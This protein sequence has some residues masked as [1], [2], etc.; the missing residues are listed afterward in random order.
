MELKGKSSRIQSSLGSKLVESNDSVISTLLI[1]RVKDINYQENYVIFVPITTNSTSRP[2]TRGTNQALLPSEFAGRNGFGRSY[3]V[4]NP[5]HVGDIVLIGLLESDAAKPIVISRYPDTKIASELTD[6]ASE[7]YE[8]ADFSNYATANKR[9]IVYPDQGYNIHDGRGN[10]TLKFSGNTFM[11]VRPDVPA[12]SHATDDGDTPINAQNIPGNSDS[13]GQSRNAI[14]QN[15]PEVIYGHRGNIN[16]DGTKDNHAY[17]VYIGQDGDY[18]VSMMQDDQDWRTY[19]EET[20]DGQIR[21][22]RQEDSKIFGTGSKSSEFLIDNNGYVTIRSQSTGLVLK[23]DGIYNL[24]GTKFTVDTDLSG[25]WDAI[26]KT[27]NGVKENKAQITVNANEI[28]TKVSTDELPTAIN[29]QLKPYDDSL[30]SLQDSYTDVKKT[31]DNMASDGIISGADKKATRT[32]WLQIQTEYPATVAQAEANGVDHSSLDTSYNTLSAYLEPILNAGGDTTVDPTE[33]DRNFSN[34]YNASFNVNTAIVAALRKLAQD[35]YDKAVQAGEDVGNALTQVSQATSED[36]LTGADKATLGHVWTQI[37]NQ[38][39]NDVSS[40]DAVKVDHNALDGAYNDLN[41][42]IQT[43]KIFADNSTI[44]IDGETLADKIKAYFK[45]EAVV[46]KQVADKNIQTLAEYGQDIDHQAT[47]IK[48]TSTKIALSAENIQKHSDSLSVMQGQLNVMA[49]QISGGVS[50]TDVTGIVNDSLSGT[51]LGQ[52]NQ[53]VLKTATKGQYM[54]GNNG[55]SSASTNGIISDYVAVTAGTA[56]SAKVY[57][58]TG[59]IKLSVMWYDSNKSFISGTE[60][61]GTGDVTNNGTAPTNASYAKVSTD[62]Y[63]F[64]TLFIAGNAPSAWAPSYVDAKGNVD[65]ANQLLKS[66]T[67]EQANISA[68]INANGNKKK[69]NV[70]NIDSMFANGNLV[71]TDIGALNGILTDISSDHSSDNSL[72]TQY[73]VDIAALNNYYGQLKDDING[74]LGQAEGSNVDIDSYRAKLTAYYTSRDT[75]LQAVKGKID[76]Q[77]SSAKQAL[78]NASNTANEVITNKY[79]NFA[80]TV[81]GISTKVGEVTTTANNASAAASTAQSSAN[82]AQSSANAAKDSAAS[83]ASAA[84]T[85]QVTANAAQ[86]SATNAASAASAAASAASATQKSL[87]TLTDDGNIS[88]IEKQTLAKEYATIKSNKAIDLAQATKYSVDA[89][90]YTNAEQAVET[91]VIPILNDMTT[92]TAVDRDKYKSTFSTYYNERTNLLNA[93]ADVAKNAA[94][95]AASAA[96]VA[97]GTAN[98]AAS[99]ASAAQSDLNNFKTTTTQKFSE[100]D[101]TA[102]G[103]KQSVSDVT[104]TANN[105]STA[106]STAQSSANNAQTTATSAA[107]AASAAQA[108]ASAAQASATTANS[109]ASAA[110]SAASTAQAS[111]NATQSSLDAL[112]DDGNIS[113]IEKQTLAKEYA[114]IQSNK[115]VDLA[116]ATKYSVDATSYTNAEA[117]VEVLANQLLASMSTSTFVNRDSYKSTFATYY[118]ARTQL[119]NAI[120]DVAKNAASAAASAASAAQGTANT[121]Q[122]TASAAQATANAAQSDLNGFKTTTTQKFSEI[123]QTA[124]GIKQSVSAVTTTANNASDKI[125]NLQVGGTN[126]LPNTIDFSSWQM[127]SGVSVDKTVYPGVAHYP[128][129]KAGSDDN[130][131]HYDSLTSLVANNTYTFSFS[132]KGSG[133]LSVY[134]YPSVAATGAADNFHQYALTSTYQKYSFTFTA[135]S[136]ISG[137]KSVLFR[138]SNGNTLEAYITQV[139]LEQGNTAT[140][141]SPAPADNA[142]LATVNNIGQKNLVYN[143]EIT[144]LDGWTTDT[145]I[146]VNSN[147]WDSYNGSN[148]LGI[149]ATGLGANDWRYV[150][151]NPVN[152]IAGQEYSVMG[153]LFFTG[154]LGNPLPASIFLETDFF[155]ASGTRVGF[156]SV[157]FDMTRPYDKQVLKLEGIMPPST[158]V[159]MRLAVQVQGGTYN[160]MLNHPML[161]AFPT[162]G[163]YQPDTASTSD[164]AATNKTV[165]TV[166]TQTANNWSIFA[167]GIGG[168]SAGISVDGNGTVTISG[169]KLVIGSDFIAGNIT[170]KTITGSSFINYYQHVKVDNPNIVRLNYITNSDQDVVVGNASGQAFT[171]LPTQL[172]T[173]SGPYVFTAQL[174]NANAG[175]TGV[176]IGRCDPSNGN[177]NVE[178]SDV[179]IVNGTITKKFTGTDNPNYTALILY[180]NTGAWGGSN[181][182]VITYHHYKLQPGSN[183]TPWIT[184]SSENIIYATG[185]TQIADHNMESK[186]AIEDSNSQDTG[187]RYDTA[188][189]PVGF[190]NHIDTPDGAGSVYN[191]KVSNGILNMTSLVNDVA[192]INK[193]YISSSFRATDNV[194]YYWNNTTAYTDA[195]VAWGYIYYARRGNLCTAAFDILAKGA[196]GWLDLAQPRPGYKPYLAQATGGT[197]ASVS[198][199]SDKCAVYYVAGGYWRLIPSAGRGEYRGSVSYI[200]QDDY[201]TGDPFF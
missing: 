35:G 17:Y 7:H 3:G 106:A 155:D 48:E 36:Y 78:S 102:D 122:S 117:A 26:T 31:I 9:T 60:K 175:Q 92:N 16:K 23:P 67:D 123:D 133:P 58:A 45:Q 38:Y 182:K 28:A 138:N 180:P 129:N 34:Y 141:W 95:A 30:K 142:T 53:F 69:T 77:V 136:T 116:Q 68:S 83:A 139:K 47:A 187:Y 100:I 84:S 101:Q 105:A 32:I 198:Y 81:D 86:A 66:L 33:W 132:A 179:S 146:S 90:A 144:S 191:L 128:S 168:T 73:G 197:L 80:V 54:N 195:D 43:N 82:N 21:L 167:Q 152:V 186:G 199:P 118:N 4:I 51:G 178:T 143:S 149:H 166:Q 120:A 64:N 1:A 185:E 158:A 183:P 61:T 98:S 96:S 200:T 126:M 59:T 173:F 55:S 169:N 188:I 147:Q 93:I 194:T 104:T 46:L 65:S 14:V 62:N 112:T 114:T 161:V 41:T 40:A 177:N 165:K 39:P 11:L 49:N 12:V 103:I 163:P 56:Y 44:P 42:Y 113:P 127:S 151:S 24:D 189:S 164:L 15:A 181:G 63:N 172:G 87:D 135:S 148:S 124:D 125:N 134:I 99:A 88:P 201:P 159:T 111:A 13:S 22:R 74:L 91:M 162:I 19:F 190:T 70:D 153:T 2:S 71:S 131:L 89:T 119:L 75:F 184:P 196:Q 6:Q 109:A 18:R 140:D 8:P 160:F 108:T 79:A 121:A 27:Q 176:T 170:G 192:A 110:A 57:G 145:G 85:A 37:Q 5:I 154:P 10:L 193:K 157:G 107:S 25:V 52:T 130:F 137:T 150:Y 94:S 97:Q 171:I 115:T 72:A 174:T 20:P 76:S 29:N 156:P 50:E